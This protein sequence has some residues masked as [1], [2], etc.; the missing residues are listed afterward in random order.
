MGLL[1]K[2]L[3]ADWLRIG[4]A[5]VVAGAMV[6]GVL[7]VNHWRLDSGRLDAA[8]AILKAELACA[9]GSECN[10]RALQAAVDGQAAVEKARQA[11]A[12]AASAQ[13]A[14][15]AADVQVQLARI[16]SEAQAATV[17]ASAWRA[18]YEAAVSRDATCRAWSESPVPC[19]IL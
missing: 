17:R 9:R 10:R 1:L 2:W 8:Q 14:K 16:A 4:I 13:Q 18:R 15:L 12:E 6:W 19:P 5:V 3:G 11:A 7:L